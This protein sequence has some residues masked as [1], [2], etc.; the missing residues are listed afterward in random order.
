[1]PGFRQQFPFNTAKSRHCGCSFLANVLLWLYV[2]AV[3]VFFTPGI[4]AWEKA[5]VVPQVLL[6]A[7]RG[8][9]WGWQVIET[10]APSAAKDFAHGG[11]GADTASRCKPFWHPPHPPMLDE[12]LKQKKNIRELNRTQKVYEMPVGS[13][14][15]MQHGYYQQISIALQSLILPCRTYVGEQ[16]DK[17]RTTQFRKRASEW[18]WQ[19]K[20]PCTHNI[21]SPEELWRDWLVHWYATGPHVSPPKKE[22]PW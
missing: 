15:L 16:T 8:Q 12:T 10:L 11:R 13:L 21:A 20:M 7:H 17:I 9:L 2:T 4:L 6:Q 22:R 19:Y 3:Y 1:M 18:E 5:V 14:K